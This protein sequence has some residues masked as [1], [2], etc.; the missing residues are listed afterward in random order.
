[1]LSPSIHSF[2]IL[3]R[4]D[5]VLEIIAVSQYQSIKL[6]IF[7]QCTIDKTNETIIT[8]SCIDNTGT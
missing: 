6:K 5:F 1:M 8:K 7:T 4:N 3:G 2:C